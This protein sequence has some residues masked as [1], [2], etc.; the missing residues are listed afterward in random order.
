MM[1]RL[2]L[3]ALAVGVAPT[4]RAQSPVSFRTSVVFESY[5]FDAGL[6]FD[7]LSE[8]TIPVTARIDFGR[9]GNLVISSGFAS[10]DLSSAD[11][12]QL[13]DQQVS[14]ALDTQARLSFNVVP[15]RF[16]FLVTGAAP[17]GV[18]TVE[19]DE[20][21]VLGAIS[22]DLIGFAIS[23]LG[24][25][26][27][28][29]AGFAGAIPVGRMA[30][31]FGATFQ[32]P[33]RYEPVAGSGDELRSG[34]EFRL[35]GGLE[36]AIGSRTYIRFAG[37]FARRGKD[38][39]NDVT[40]NGVGHRLV[41]YLSVNQGLG[42]SA[43]LTV[44]GFDVFRSDPQIEAT[45]VG[46][47]VLPRGNL[48]AAGARLAFTVA[49]GTQITPRVE[50]RG[51]AAAPDTTDT[52]LQKLGDSFRFGVELRRRLNPGLALVLQGG[53]LT[54]DVRQS[55]TDVGFTGYRAG[56]HLEVTP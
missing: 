4:V 18:Q 25:G 43:S 8:L 54:G 33:F 17:T 15:D 40:Q 42:R 51:S 28:V 37:I 10:V 53:G 3:A 30:V 56:L 5:S 35:R 13:V 24:T 19:F 47:A 50:Y 46:A 7:H 38:E 6:S 49:P 11:P 52:S 20:L 44:Y 45:A 21:S 39:I 32:Q 9:T 16:V 23:E 27:N 1:R 14:G 34:N 48:V 22:S 41:G 2:L 26:G 29:G 55:G 36:G 12:T 31:G